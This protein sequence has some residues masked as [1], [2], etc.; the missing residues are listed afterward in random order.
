MEYN[1]IALA[2]SKVQ[3]AQ[4]R[5]QLAV[6]LGSFFYRQNPM[7]NLNIWYGVCRLGPWSSYGLGGGS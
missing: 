6:E 3:D 5:I 1:A 4:I 7:F 2:I